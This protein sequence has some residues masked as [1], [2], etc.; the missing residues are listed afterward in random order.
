MNYN[1]NLNKTKLN[2]I[3]R[4][5]NFEETIKVNLNEI[6]EENVIN[7]NPAEEYCEENE[8]NIDEKLLNKKMSVN[9][10]VN[11]NIKD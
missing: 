3:K 7:T 9:L 6:V 4:N 10:N 11:I 1:S 5:I 2:E 8:N